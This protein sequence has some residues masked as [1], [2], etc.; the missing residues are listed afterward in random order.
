MF[1]L[2]LRNILRS[3]RRTLLTLLSL[4]GGYL[5][6]ALQLS[7]TEGSYDQ[8]LSTYTR[9]TTGHVQITAEGYVETPRLYDS[10]SLND[11]DLSELEAQPNV[12][13]VTPRIESSALAYGE[14]KSFPVDVVGIDPQ[15][16]AGLSF[17]ADKL[18]AGTYLTDQPDTDGYFAAMIGA[19]VARQLSVGVGDELVLVSQGADGSLANDLYRVSAIVGTIDSAESRRVVLPL[20]AAQ[21]FYAM[22]GKVHRL[23][24]L[25]RDYRRAPQLAEQLDGWAGQHWDDTDVG[26]TSWQVVAA[27]FYRTM[28]ADKSGGQVTMV[29]LIF[30]VCVGVLNTILMSVMERT[31]EFGV[32]KAIGTSPGRLFRLIM[33]EA[34]LLAILACLLALILVLP[35]NAWF[36]WVGLEIEPIEFSGVLFTRYAGQMSFYVFAQP[37]LLIVVAT[38]IA[39]LWPAWRAA[40][41]VPVEAMRRL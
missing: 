14:T 4:G 5:L 2:A 20:R 36:T 40:R 7:V 26:A 15:R 16:E 31:G 13:A 33:L 23:I 34:G 35:I 19:Q 41:L 10:L 21:Q 32:L 28:E 29:I 22:P 11:A 37:A 27:D 25:G 39:A 12:V 17:L 30:L 18:R 24:V 38:L 3:R 6:T 9:D 1:K 8:M